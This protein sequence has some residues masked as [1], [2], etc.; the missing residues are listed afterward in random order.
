MDPRSSS[1]RHCTACRS[2]KKLPNVRTERI[3]LTGP[4]NYTAWLRAFTF[5]AERKGVLGFFSSVYKG[6]RK[7]DWDRDM[8]EIRAH[9]VDLTEAELRALQTRFAFCWHAYKK[10]RKRFR[11]AKALIIKW[12][13]PAIGE[14]LLV[15]GKTPSDALDYLRKK[16]MPK[17]PCAWE[18]VEPER[19]RFTS[20]ILRPVMVFLSEVR[21]HPRVEQQGAEGPLPRNPSNNTHDEF[22]A[23]SASCWMTNDDDDDVL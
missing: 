4:E 16:Y 18:I 2:L 14:E 1:Q 20:W 13:H 5:E 6:P 9:G 23:V 10:D 15:R 7:P 21:A 3:E 8:A 19:G 22:L 11:W 12:V 17:I